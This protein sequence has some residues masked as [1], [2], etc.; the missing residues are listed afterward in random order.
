[1]LG[2][3]RVSHR[4]V[5]DPAPRDG[6]GRDRPQGAPHLPSRR[7]RVPPLGPCPPAVCELLLPGGHHLLHRLPGPRRAA[8]PRRHRRDRSAGR[9]RGVRRQGLRRRS[10]PPT[11]HHRRGAPEHV[12]LRAGSR[13]RRVRHRGGAPPRRR[14]PRP[15]PGRKAPWFGLRLRA[16]NSL[17]GARHAVYAASTLKDARL[18]AVIETAPE[19]L[20]VTTV[21]DQPD[22]D[23]IRAGVDGKI[24]HFL[25]PGEG[26]L[27]AASDA[28]IKKLA[29]D[30]AKE[31]RDHA[32]GWAGK[33]TKPQIAQLEKLSQR[34][35]ELW[36]LALR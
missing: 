31:L 20:P 10:D 1:L 30:A 15:P 17:I 3:A 22:A 21:H 13:L 23:G 14:V 9:R 28:E 32:K 26:W 12:A 5:H 36:G 11:A 29:P 16:G 7:V 35:E 2:G 27:A 19:N 25:L 6:R 33:L 34:V 24:F 18:K 8:R 4:R